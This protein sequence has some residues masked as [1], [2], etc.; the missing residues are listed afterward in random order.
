[1][2]CSLGISNFLEEISSVSHSIVFIYFFALEICKNCIGNM[3]RK[4]FL[5]LL[6][7]LWNSAFR[8][9]YLS[10]PP[11]LFTSLL[12]SAICK[13]S[14]DNHFMRR[15]ASKFALFDLVK[16][17]EKESKKRKIKQTLECFWLLV[18]KRMMIQVCTNWC[19]SCSH[20]VP[21][22]HQSEMSFLGL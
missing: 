19:E 8:R 18:M 11:L 22:P 1:M 6:A 2:K 16:K 5:S 14:S 21:S 3:L 12:F 4:A 15:P 17:R 20:F 10:F 13:A 7:I 9:V